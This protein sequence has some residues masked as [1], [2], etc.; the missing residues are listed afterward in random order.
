MIYIKV[1]QNIL[2]KLFKDSDQ[3]NNLIRI[4]NNICIDFQSNKIRFYLTNNIKIN[5][6]YYIE[7]NYKNIKD[8]SDE[9]LMKAENKVLIIQN[10]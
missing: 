7:D 3:S 8:L 4:G 5:N 9:E 6:I 10:N 2:T 1:T